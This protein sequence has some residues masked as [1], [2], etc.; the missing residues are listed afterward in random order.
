MTARALLISGTVG[1]GKTTVADAVGDLLSARPIP[2]A[3]LDLDWLSR[4]W[5]CPPGDPFNVSMRLRNVRVVLS[6]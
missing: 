3:V 6:I 2:N 1:A 4:S 5:P